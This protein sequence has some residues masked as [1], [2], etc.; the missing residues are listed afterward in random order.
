M[1]S[2]RK[3]RKSNKRNFSQLENFN[4]DIIIGNTASDRQ[5]TTIVNEGTGDHGFTVG[6]SDNNLIANEETV[7]EKTLERCSN[8]RIDKEMTKILILLTRSK[9]E[10]ETEF[11]PQL[12][13]LLPS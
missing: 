6:I 3:K 9:T 11:W 5:E 13:V 4:P 12:T 10:S 8:E 1:V 2:T 7:N